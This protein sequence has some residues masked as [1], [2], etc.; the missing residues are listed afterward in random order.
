MGFERLSVREQRLEDI[1]K[2]VEYFLNADHNFL[3]NMGVDASKLPSK[4]EWIDALT[5]NYY[6]DNDEKSIYYIIWLIKDKPVGHCNINKIV[7]KDKAYLHLHLW[8]SITRHKGL[9]AKFLKLSIPFFFEIFKLKKLYCEPY[10]LNAAPN[11][12]L[13]KLGFDLLSTYETV[14]GSINFKQ[15]VNR[16]CLTEEK[17]QL[18]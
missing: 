2:I 9:G 7:L 18:I 16:W 6:L 3:L 8:Q 17:W 15:Q 11:K 1:Q 5:R 12:T 10:A 4:Q 13:H 14:P